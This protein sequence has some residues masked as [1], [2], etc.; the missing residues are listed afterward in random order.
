MIVLDTNVFSDTYFCKWL[1]RSNHEAIVSS[2]SY[3][4]LAYHYLKRG[5]DIDYLDNFLQSLGIK[6]VEYT[7]E[8]A[9]IAAKLSTKRWDFRK[10]ARDYM[11]ASI[12]IKEDCPLITYNVNDFAFLHKNKLFTP[13]DFIKEQEGK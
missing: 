10:N 13:E 4:E 3:T 5:K 8:Q 11:I 1:A 12:A 2:I 9:K 6:V 7:R